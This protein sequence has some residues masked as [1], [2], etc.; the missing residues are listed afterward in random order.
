MFDFK[1]KK[2]IYAKPL[3]LI[4]KSYSRALTQFCVILVDDVMR[5][6][7]TVRYAVYRTERIVPNG[8]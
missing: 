3:V 1:V 2:C 8:R 4:E 5:A 6:T 7:L